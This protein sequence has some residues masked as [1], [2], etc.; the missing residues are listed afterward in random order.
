MWLRLAMVFSIDFIFTASGAALAINPGHDARKNVVELSLP[1]TGYGKESENH[2]QS[3]KHALEHD[4][5]CNTMLKQHKLPCYTY[6][7]A[8]ICM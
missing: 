7:T 2:D 1:N 6:V 8:G 5:L 3:E 4:I